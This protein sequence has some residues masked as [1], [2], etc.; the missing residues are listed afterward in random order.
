ML[1]LPYQGLADRIHERPVRRIGDQY[2]YPMSVDRAVHV[3]LP[4]PFHDLEGPGAIIAVIPFEI[5]EG[6]HRAMVLP[7][8][9]IFGRVQQ[10]VLHYEAVGVILVMR[11]IQINLAVVNHRSRVRGVFRLDDRHVDVSVE[12]PPVKVEEFLVSAVE[13]KI[14]VMLAGNAGTHRSGNH[15]VVVIDGNGGNGPPLYHLV[16]E[17]VYAA[18]I[19]EVEHL[20]DDHRR[21]LV[22]EIHLAYLD[23]VAVVN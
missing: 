22:T 10:P 19:L 11:G 7:V 6:C 5:L 4:V 21:F 16:N 20:D 23:P 18:C 15:H 13:E 8:D 9:H 17:E 12:L 14:D 2:S 3:E 1:P